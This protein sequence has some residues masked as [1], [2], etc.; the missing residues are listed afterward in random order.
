MPT[1]DQTAAWLPIFVEPDDDVSIPVT[2]PVGATTGTWS[3][4]LYRDSRLGTAL[5]Q[6]GTNLAGEVLTIS[7][8]SE[9]V[10]A[11]L[12]ADETRFVGY[13]VLTRT[14]SSDQRTWLKGLFVVDTEPD[15]ATNGSTAVSLA[16]NTTTVTVTATAASVQ[17][18]QMQA[19][20]APRPIKATYLTAAVTGVA[21]DGWYVHGPTPADFT[22]RD[23]PVIWEGTAAQIPTQGTGDTQLQTGDLVVTR[24]ST[25]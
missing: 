9:T 24:T 4:Y 25:L 1:V 8:P 18:A 17:Y 21:T 19:L 16:L 12:P 3:A 2:L 6:F 13:W 15:V 20:A 10:D 22:G 7:L 14:V 5:A 11:L 23:W